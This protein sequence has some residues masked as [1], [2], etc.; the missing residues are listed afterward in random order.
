MTIEEAIGGLKRI[1]SDHELTL[2]FTDSAAI[3]QIAIYAMENRVPKKAVKYI[4]GD[5]ED[6]IY[7]CPDCD[8]TY[9]IEEYGEPVYCINCGQ[10]LEFE[11]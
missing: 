4:E 9:D 6:Y 5:P 3:L 1:F 7:M 8:T 11:L 2:P 10:K